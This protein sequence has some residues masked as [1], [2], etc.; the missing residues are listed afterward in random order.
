MAVYRYAVGEDGALR[1][2]QVSEPIEALWGLPAAAFGG[3]LAAVRATVHPE[4]EAL[5]FESVRRASAGAVDLSSDFRVALPGGRWRW[6][7]AHAAPIRLEDGRTVYDGFLEDLTPRRH[8]EEALREADGLLAEF[9]GHSPIYVY[10]KEVSPGESRVL[11]ASENFVQL[12]GIPGSRMAGKTMDELFPADSAAQMT[13]DDWAVVSTGKVLEVEEVL[14]GRTYSTVKFP[15]ALGTRRL[16][17]GYTIDVTAQRRAEDARRAL[18]RQLLQAQRKDS[19]GVMAGG[20]AHHFNNLLLI[21]QSNLDMAR[22]RVDREVTTWLDDAQDAVRRAAAISGSLRSYVGQGENHREPRNLG[23]DLPALRPLLRA[24][25]P[26]TVGLEFE[27]DEDLPPVTIDPEGLRQVVWNVVTNAWEA[28]GPKGGLVR[29]VARRVTNLAAETGEQPGG[30]RRAG[31][32][33]CL[34]V[35][36]DGEGMDAETRERMFDPFF[37]TRFTG[38]GLGLAVTLGIIRA[39]GGFIHV[40]SAPRKGTTVRIYLPQ[41]TPMELAAARPAADQPPPAA[42]RAPRQGA[43]LLVDDDPLVLSSSHRLL[44][45]LGH[46]VFTAASGAEA[47]ELFAAQGDFIGSVLLDL[48]MPGLDGWDVLAALRK[49]R[50]DVYVVVASGYDLGELRKERR[51]V[52]PDGWLQKPFST[53]D[54]S[55]LLPSG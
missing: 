7:H 6:L 27:L 55:L 40:E 33:L 30:A 1:V 24:G 51:E 5:L 53:A 35:T 23:D 28:I 36:D 34:E 16:L 26:S 49:M 42:P 19:L 41:S 22:E 52:Q 29:V 47:I 31:P 9:I 8:A 4:D 32:W 45:R 38:R 54:L 48:N 14:R 44:R 39:N 43:V 25:V 12:V 11:R 17:A 37:S 21:I 2:L 10:V 20:I 18:E 13:A 46:R 50:P 15:I 3:D